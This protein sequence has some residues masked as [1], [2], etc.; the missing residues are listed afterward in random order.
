VGSE[1]PEHGMRDGVPA[2][3]AAVVTAV[4]GQEDEFLG[5][6]DWEKA[7]EDLIE[8]S[9]NGGVSADAKGESEDG[10]YSEAG[11][12]GEGAQGVLKIAKCG[13]KG[14]HYVHFADLSFLSRLADYCEYAL[15]QELFPANRPRAPRDG[16]SLSA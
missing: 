5:I 16:R 14:G 3:I 6:F 4:H 2:P 7:E 11:G 10:N 8:E 13:V 15:R 9:E 12:A 1:I